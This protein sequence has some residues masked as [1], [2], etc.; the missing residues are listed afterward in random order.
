[1]ID[2]I[3]RLHQGF[4]RAYVDDIVIYT[5]SKFLAEHLIHLDKVFKS[6]AEKGICL[7]PK[8]SFLGYP[9]VQLLGQCVNALGLATAK[10]KLAAI[11]NIK[12][13]RTL[14]ALE[15]YLGMTGYLLQYIPYY[16]AIIKPLQERKTRLNYNLQ[17]LW[18]ERKPTNGKNT[19]VGGNARKSL[20]G[21]TAIEEPTPSELDSFHQLQNLFSRPTILIHYD[22][23]RQLYADMDASK[24]FG[25]GAHVYHMKESHGLT[26]GQKNVESILFLSKALAN[27]ET[28]YWPTELE[29]AGLVW[30]VRKICH[31]LESA[32]KPTIVYT[33][34]SATLGIVHQSSLTSTTSIDKMNLQLVR[35]SKY[36]QR[37]CLDVRHKAGKM[38]VVPDAL[39]RLVS[40][41]TSNLLDQ[42]LDSLAVDALTITIQSRLEDRTA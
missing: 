20:A 22:L 25:F 21:R 8:K 9:A 19:N 6:L 39:S 7:S 31:M 41:S 14:S 18:A 30:L 34:H 4:S 40:T 13:P 16:A 32:E 11:V 17:K 38:N 1:M 27:T 33:D 2:R 36:L 28:R 35:A 29:V 12:F 37:F 23:K 3:L 24:E 26:S 15:K 10:D 42:S 5:K